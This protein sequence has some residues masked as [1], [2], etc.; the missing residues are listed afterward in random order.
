MTDNIDNAT[1]V[2]GAAVDIPPDPGCYHFRVFSNELSKWMS[3]GSIPIR[4][5]E[6]EARRCSTSL[7][8]VPGG[9]VICRII[10]IPQQCEQPAPAEGDTVV[11]SVEQLARHIEAMRCATVIIENVERGHMPDSE[12]I[13]WA[14]DAIDA[15]LKGGA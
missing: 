15:I 8:R 9:S 11:V 10:R 3:W 4:V 2:S 12:T 13:A 5:G 14:R 6:D 1:D 7:W